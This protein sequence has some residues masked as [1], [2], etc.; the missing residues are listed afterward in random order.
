MNQ[1]WFQCAGLVLSHLSPTCLLLCRSS[2][3]GFVGLFYVHTHVKFVARKAE[4]KTMIPLCP[5]DHFLLQYIGV[6][7]YCGLC[8]LPTFVDT[9][10]ARSGTCFESTKTGQIGST[11]GKRGTKNAELPASTESNWLGPASKPP[12]TVCYFGRG[13]LLFCPTCGQRPSR[14]WISWDIVQN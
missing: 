6:S 10:H 9:F 1:M 12:K 7:F 3:K 14:G 11:N 5:T 13:Y 4:S 2:Q 8:P